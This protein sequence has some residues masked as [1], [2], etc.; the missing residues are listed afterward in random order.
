MACG[1]FRTPCICAFWE[2]PKYRRIFLLIKK[3]GSNG[4]LK[5]NLVKSQRVIVTAFFK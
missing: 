5:I 1:V 4:N 2:T 3:N